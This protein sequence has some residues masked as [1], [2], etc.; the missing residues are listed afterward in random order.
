M[1]TLPLQSG[2]P[3][4]VRSLYVDAG[5]IE[6]V[7]SY[8]H[9][10]ASVDTKTRLIHF[11]SG[12]YGEKLLEVPIGRICPNN[13]IRVTVGLLKEWYEEDHDRDPRVGISAE[14]RRSADI[15]AISV[16]VG[17]QKKWYEQGIDRD[18]RVGISDG[19]GHSNTFKIHD[20][21]NY[22]KDTPCSLVYGSHDN[23]LI[24]ETSPF[25]ATVK[26]TFNPYMRYGVCETPQDSGFMNTGTYHQKMDLTEPFYLRLNRD[27]SNE[28][29]NF[30]YFKVEIYRD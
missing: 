21:T 2:S 8:L 27:N 26:L 4:V 5:N 17:L 12:E 19:A 15:N 14:L 24:S 9:E 13:V 20:V 29:Y 18:P 11:A 7:A 1:C 30:F 10:T 22:A 3:G 23:E 28:E 6:D 16:T 25:S